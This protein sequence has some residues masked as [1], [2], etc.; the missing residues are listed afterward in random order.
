MPRIGR[1][2]GVSRKGSITR[3]VNLPAEI[4]KKCVW[5][6]DR[7]TKEALADSFDGSQ[8]PEYW[9]VPRVMSAILAEYFES[10]EAQDPTLTSYF[11]NCR[12]RDANAKSISKSPTQPKTFGY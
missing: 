3:N 9:S 2:R 12:L 11:E 5:I 7:W 1:P 8:D 4:Y 10:L 6:S